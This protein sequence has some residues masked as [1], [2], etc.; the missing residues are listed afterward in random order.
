MYNK[1]GDFSTDGTVARLE[2][3]HGFVGG[4][5]STHINSELVI[6]L[7]MYRLIYVV[8]VGLLIVN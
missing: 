1:Q 7:Q 2:R 8:N 5:D 6:T 3:E 4:T